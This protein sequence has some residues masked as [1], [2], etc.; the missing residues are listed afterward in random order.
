MTS[1]TSDRPVIRVYQPGQVC[2]VSVCGHI[3]T[4]WVQSPTGD[5]TDSVLVQIP[6]R[7]TAQANKV[8][9]YWASTWE[10]PAEFVGLQS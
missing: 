5:Q 7:D 9:C 1:V 2:A 6:C 3:V 10:I 4:V 8:A